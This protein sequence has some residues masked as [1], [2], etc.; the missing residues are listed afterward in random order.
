MLSHYAPFI[1]IGSFFFFLRVA[2]KG[3]TLRGTSK[4]TWLSQLYNFLFFPKI[5]IV[6]NIIGLFLTSAGSKDISF[7]FL[8]KNYVDGKKR[9][10]P[11]LLGSII[12]RCQ[13]NKVSAKLPGGYSHFGWACQFD[14]ALV[15]LLQ[16]QR[17]NT[18]WVL[19]RDT[20]PKEAITMER[21]QE[22][23]LKK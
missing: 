18:L 19:Q 5:L 4:V 2:N 23:K 9:W 10:S 22:K 16:K 8:K 20:T 7:A 11:S 3:R 1:S 12:S 21:A 14:R 17:G 15:Q 6:L 13:I